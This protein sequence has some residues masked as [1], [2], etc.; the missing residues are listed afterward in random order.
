MRHVQNIY[1]SIFYFNNIS[2]L[3]FVKY[4]ETHFGTFK[5]KELFSEPYKKIDGQIISTKLI[6]SELKNIIEKEDKKSPFTD[7]DLTDLL[8]KNE[9]YI[10]RRTVAKY[11][12]SLGIKIA[13]L[14]MVL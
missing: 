5:L 1:S 12:D 11:R 2:L 9:Y 10:A 7:E 14:R 6:K 4:V 3:F 13:K 8:S